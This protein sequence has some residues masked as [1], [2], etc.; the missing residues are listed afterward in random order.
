[1]PTRTAD[2]WKKKPKRTS[3][4]LE[5]NENGNTAYQNLWDI[6]KTALRGKFVAINVHIKE[7]ALSK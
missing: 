3:K 4:N 7:K 1:M 6:A 2:G 5:S